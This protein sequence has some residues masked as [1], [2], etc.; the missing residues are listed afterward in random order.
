M[1]QSNMGIVQ[2][3]TDQIPQTQKIKKKIQIN[4]NWEEV[5]F[6]RIPVWGTD[7]LV[8][9]SSE[10]E[11]WCYEHYSDPV[12]LGRWYKISGHIILDERTYVHWKL[13]E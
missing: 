6:I 9:G 8:K 4:G 2:I 13:C 10:L 1:V 5:Q 11:K 12:Y 7:R 3:I